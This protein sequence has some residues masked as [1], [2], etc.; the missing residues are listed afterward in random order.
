MDLRSPVP[1]DHPHDPTSWVFL[2]LC[3]GLL[4]TIE[5]VYQSMFCGFSGVRVVFRVRIV[6]VVVSQGGYEP[7]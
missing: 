5:S 3:S 1:L 2:F 4:H 7:I 6:R